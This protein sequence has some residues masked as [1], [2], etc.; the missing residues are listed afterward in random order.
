MTRQIVLAGGC[1]WG[2]QELFRGQPGVVA[3][4][5]GYAGGSA[6]NPTYDNHDGHAEALEIEY[7]TET[8]SLRSLLD[9][10]FTIHDPTTLNQQGND[11]GTSYRST[12]LYATDDDK[13]AAVEFID[14]VDKSGR[15]KNP[16]VTQ[17]EP[18][19]KFYPAEPVHQ[20]YLQ[21]NPGGYTCHFVRFGSYL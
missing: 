5:V 11:R 17:L 7:D 14:L 8:T 4:R 9:F 3:S 6:Q 16:V 20:D 10:F 18:L 15:W 12:I 2:L 13:R 21:K 19:A 1:F